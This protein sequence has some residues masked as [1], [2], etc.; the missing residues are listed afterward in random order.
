MG[1]GT[2]TTRHNFAAIG[3]RFGGFAIP[4]EKTNALMQFSDAYYGCD[5]EIM[6]FASD[7]LSPFYEATVSDIHRALDVMPVFTT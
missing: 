1:I 5:V 4:N 6:G 2:L 7:R 3:K